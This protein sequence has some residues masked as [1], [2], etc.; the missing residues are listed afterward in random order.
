MKALKYSEII[1]RNRE[2]G[3][4][5]VGKP[6]RIA[7]LSNIV[8]NQI[9]EILEFALRSQGVYAEVVYGDYDNIVQDSLRLNDVDAALMFWEAANLVDGLHVRADE[10]ADS[11]LGA[12]ASKVKDELGLV[13][14][15][16]SHTPLVLLNRFTALPFCAN[17]LRCCALEKLCAELN[18]VL[19][20]QQMH[21]L[22]IIDTEKIMSKV[23]L[24]FATDF[25]QYQ[26]SKALYALDFLKGYVGHVQPVFLSVTGK[27][28][29]LLVLDCDNTLWGGV[30]GEDG[31]KEIQ[32]GENTRAGKVFL[33]VQNILKGMKK[34][35]IMLA[36]CSK[37]NLDDV[38]HVF[39]NHPGMVLR[40]DDFV[41]KRVNWQDKASNLQALS[42]ELNIGLD[43][44]VFVDDSDFELGLVREAVPEV[45]TL[46]VPDALSEYPS[47]LREVR[48]HFF[49]MSQTV[50]DAGKTEMYHLERERKM[51]SRQ[52]SSVEDYLRSLELTVHI[53]WDNEIPVDRAAQLTQ[54]TNQFNLTTRRYT[55]T[56][57]SRFLQDGKYLIATLRLEDRFGDYGVTGLAIVEM[58]D[59]GTEARI[60]S[61][62]LSC[63]IIGRN[64]EFIF[65]DALIE[66][67]QQKQISYLSA[68]YLP[69]K[70]NSQVANF[71]DNAGFMV[72]GKD[73]MHTSYRIPLEAYRKQQINY[74][75]VTINEN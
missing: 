47:A 69:T 75:E 24:G 34:Q 40:N 44:M 46:A 51:A 54:K 35:G 15:N 25:R 10:M 11:E 9:G 39:D 43:S 64:V 59:L 5:C 14:A 42:Q 55:E 16:L 65:V 18:D 53:L 12:I 13:L 7:L 30:L 21:N 49:N 37:N 48:R 58:G 61:L 62:L 68:D 19:V 1:A 45:L 41:A 67:L 57:I 60:D 56:D 28:R 33:E 22:L 71:Y 52:Y 4:T 26:S 2:L 72:T 27:G 50:E 66:M 17:E 31:E 73:A 74:I 8:V 3:K 63:R 36:L 38:E 23:G 29:K 70:K 20:M 6:Y 32:I